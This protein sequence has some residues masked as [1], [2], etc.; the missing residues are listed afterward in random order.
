[1]L[2]DRELYP[3]RLL[4]KFLWIRDLAHL[5]R[6]AW[7]RGHAITPEMR[8]Q[9]EEAVRLWR[10]LLGEGQVRMAVDALPYYS[11]AVQVLTG[12]GIAFELA[13]GAA[14]GGLGD[15]N[16]HAP[17][18]SGRFMDTTDIRALTEAMIQEKTRLFDERYF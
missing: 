3:E 15:L 8:A 1:M 4:G 12:E 11:E 17:A 14:R 5:N 9:A 2:R 16:G 6:Y 13:M 18:V 7:E 10:D